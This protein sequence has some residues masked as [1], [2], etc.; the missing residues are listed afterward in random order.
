MPAEL[1]SAPDARLVVF[2]DDWG[3]HPSSCQHII[4]AL[5]ARY[6]VDWVN[7][8]GT[9]R[10]RFRL[11]DLARGVEKLIQ[12]MRR[13]RS[14][15]GS[16][17]VGIDASLGVITVHA[18]IHWPGFGTTLERAI[19]RQLLLRSLH[20]VLQRAPPP[21]AIITTLPITADLAR[22]TAELNWIYYC[23]DD[24]AA[25]PGLDAE[26]LRRMEAEQLPFMRRIVAAS[27]SLCADL[28][29]RGFKAE[30]LTHGVDLAPWRAIAPRH[31]TNGE[32]PVA[33]F[34]GLADRRLDTGI[35]N[36]IADRVRL[37]IVGPRDDVDPALR[38]H[39]NIE[40]VE[41]VPHERLPLEATRADVLVM[42]YADLPVTRSMQP[43]K[44]LEYLATDLPVVVTPLPANRSWSDALDLAATP[45]AFVAAVVE[46]IALG[47]PESQ[48]RARAR[49]A[50]ESWQAKA[51]EFERLCLTDAT[52]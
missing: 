40:W 2:S 37:R 44:L 48:R 22:A 36:A 47:L 39:P 8:V 28:H 17:S 14:G 32:P 52:A 38:D 31:R 3:R 49:V 35:C 42:P 20:K 13:P 1:P 24:L 19:N 46:R 16:S 30:L 10:P 18:P 51:V 43:L 29:R 33:L 25:W 34:W 11:A 12:W 26:P 15:A 23:V 9:R 7:T 41:A 27:E 4:R 21:R 5:S 50:N 6:R 45:D